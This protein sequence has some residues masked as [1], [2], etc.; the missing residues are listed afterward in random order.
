[1]DEYVCKYC[2]DEYNK[3]EKKLYEFAFQG[4]HTCGNKVK[5]E[6]YYTYEQPSY[7]DAWKSDHGHLY[8]VIQNER[9][10]CPIHGFVG[11][12]MMCQDC[13]SYTT[14]YKLIKK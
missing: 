6:T 11:S 8:V 2:Y 1:M 10:V 14:D 4:H 12:K 7:I 3:E 13:N 9:E 5:S